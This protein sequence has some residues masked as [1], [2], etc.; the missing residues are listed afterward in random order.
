M[1]LLHVALF[2]A[3]E[4]LSSERNNCLSGR[5]KKSFGEALSVVGVGER[6]CCIVVLKLHNNVFG[7]KRILEKLATMKKVN[8]KQRRGEDY[9]HKKVLSHEVVILFF[10]FPFI[11][12]PP[13]A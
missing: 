12:E 11:F 3:F 13:R 10:Y 8:E 1:S 7:V 2:G 6:E 4:S 5:N 9:E